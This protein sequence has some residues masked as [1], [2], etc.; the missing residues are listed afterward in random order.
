MRITILAV[1][2]LLFTGTSEFSL[3]GEEEDRPAIAET[4]QKF[5]SGVSNYDVNVLKQAFHP[6]ARIFYT[7][8]SGEL[9]QLTQYMWYDR[10]K[11]PTK[12]PVRNNEIVSIDIAGNTAMVKTLSTFSDFRFTYYLS[13]MKLYGQWLI[14]HSVYSKAGK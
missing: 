1:S 9:K 4:V 13:L 14:V 3:A 10:I 5:F 8:R 2:L 12:P 7:T 6:D 11:R